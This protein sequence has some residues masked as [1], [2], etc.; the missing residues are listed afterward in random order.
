MK[1]K[2]VEKK[3]K[4]VLQF[5]S[6]SCNEMESVNIYLWR[7]ENWEELYSKIYEITDELQYQV[8]K[9]G[10]SDSLFS[11]FAARDSFIALCAY[12]PETEGYVL[13]LARAEAWLPTPFFCL[14]FQAAGC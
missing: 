8:D 6:E 5:S 11:D 13:S 9:C 1:V 7:T 4:R 3:K 14:T 2:D 12:V 10:P